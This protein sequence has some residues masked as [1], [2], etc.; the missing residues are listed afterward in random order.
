MFMRDDKAIS[1]VNT[2]DQTITVIVRCSFDYWAPLTMEITGLTEPS[3][4]PT[5]VAIHALEQ[6]SDEPST[7]RF[8]KYDIPKNK[9]Y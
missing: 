2:K 9:L 8:F 3:E 1:L 7:L 6:S 5:R 4:A